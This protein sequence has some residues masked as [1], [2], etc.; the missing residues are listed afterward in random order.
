MTDII[1]SAS[2]Q[3][4]WMHNNYGD[5]FI[6]Y[7][8]S[9]GTFWGSMLSRGSQWGKGVTYKLDA[10][11]NWTAHFS[12]NFTP[13]VSLVSGFEIAGYSGKTTGNFS[14]NYTTISVDGSTFIFTYSIKDYAEKR[15]L[16]LFSIPLMVKFR[17]NTF[18]DVYCMKYFAACGL[19]LVIPL[20]RVAT[21]NS[22]S[23]TTTGYFHKESIEYA[24][25]PEKG[26]VT[27]FHAPEW[28]SK[29]DLKMGVALALETGVT[30]FN[31]EDIRAGASIYCDIGLNNLLRHG[32]R[33][34]VEYQKLTPERFLFN[35][36]ATTKKVNGIEMF[37]IGLKLSVSFDL[38]KKIK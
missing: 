18:Y 31:N 23:I 33:Y 2:A 13:A 14:D 24:G 26:F 16:T 8:L 22:R 1:S 38:D 17:S 37:S 36:I 6:K 9:I 32:N 5:D 19:K 10:G 11:K 4:T 12:Y 35:S 7:E 15:N 3:V 21:I 20:E 27:D 29:M 28:R 25:F 30:F 34:M